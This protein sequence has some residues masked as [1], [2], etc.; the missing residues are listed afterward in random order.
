MNDNAQQTEWMLTGFWG[1][2]R[3][4]LNGWEPDDGPIQTCPRCHAMVL[5][6]EVEGHERWHAM[7]DFPIPEHLRKQLQEAA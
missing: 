5:K 7:T 6:G 1:N 2:F 4:Q 3:I